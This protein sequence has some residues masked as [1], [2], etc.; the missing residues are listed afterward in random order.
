MK[1]LGK[2]DAMLPCA[3]RNFE[4]MPLYRHMI[5]KDVADNLAVAGGRRRIPPAILTRV[6]V[7]ERNGLSARADIV[8][9][10]PGDSA[11]SAGLAAVC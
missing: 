7:L 4:D 6:P 1:T 9:I 5:G 8:L 2:S 3:G 11:A 10:I